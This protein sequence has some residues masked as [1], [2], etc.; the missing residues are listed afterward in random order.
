MME[1]KE[2]TFAGEAFK[3]VI[4]SAEHPRPPHI[5]VT[6]V[7]DTNNDFNVFVDSVTKDTVTI[8]CSDEYTGTVILSAISTL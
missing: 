1:R 8:Q 2:I 4:L 3:T 7:G 6:P 5:T